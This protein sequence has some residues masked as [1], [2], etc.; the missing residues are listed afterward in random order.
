MKSKKEVSALMLLMLLWCKTKHFAGL[1]REII[2]PDSRCNEWTVCGHTQVGKRETYAVL[3]AQLL[4]HNSV[5][6]TY[7]TSW[8]PDTV[9]PPVLVSNNLNKNTDILMTLGT[10]VPW[11]R[12]KLGIADGCNWALVTPVKW[13]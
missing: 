10:N 3:V 7:S 13:R 11:R 1:I 2:V 6:N 12:E 5:C 9:F 4:S 8:I